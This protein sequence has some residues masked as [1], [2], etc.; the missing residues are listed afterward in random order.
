MSP[1][2]YPKIRMSKAVA[3]ALTGVEKCPICGALQDMRDKFVTIKFDDRVVECWSCHACGHA[4]KV[5]E[6][7]VL[8]DSQYP[9]T[10]RPGTYRVE[11]KDR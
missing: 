7:Q 10:G 9:I 1:T 8:E 4:F 6:G 5:C 2:G 11:L 3:Q